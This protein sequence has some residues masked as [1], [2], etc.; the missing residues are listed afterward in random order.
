MPE[1]RRATTLD[2][3]SARTIATPDPNQNQSP[4]VGRSHVDPV[5]G[6]G[7]AGDAGHC[8]VTHESNRSGEQS[9]LP[10]HTPQALGYALPHVEGLLDFGHGSPSFESRKLRERQLRVAVDRAI[11]PD[12]GHS[13][14]RHSGQLVSGFVP[15]QVV[16]LR[17]LRSRLDLPGNQP[18]T[19]KEILA[20]DLR[21]RTGHP[22]RQKSVCRRHRTNDERQPHQ[23]NFVRTLSF[24][25][26]V[27][28]PILSS[29]EA[30]RGGG[31]PRS[32][33]SAVLG[34][35]YVAFT[36]LA[37]TTH[38]ALRNSS[39]ARPRNT[40]R[41]TSS[42]SA[43]PVAPNSPTSL[44]SVVLLETRSRTAASRSARRNISDRTGGTSIFS[45]TS[46]RTSQHRLEFLVRVTAPNAAGDEL[47]RVDS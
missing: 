10:L 45:S 22:R 13:P 41:R 24:N 23:E 19:Y 15:R 29:I 21:Q 31:G 43:T 17:R 47:V 4:N 9:S 40:A 7:D 34:S 44:L 5:K 3:A 38:F 32:G 25:G 2:S 42:G 18:R 6:H 27:I 46:S 14:S 20:Q 8:A 1:T 12:E 36:K 26:S 37:G 35:R 33:D 16:P 28:R 30:W 11:R 39:H